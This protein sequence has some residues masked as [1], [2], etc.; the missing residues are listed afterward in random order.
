M[1][2]LMALRVVSLPAT[3][4]SRTKKPNSSEERL[5][6]PSAAT[7]WLTMSAAGHSL[8]AAAMFIE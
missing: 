4:S 6:W 2:W 8:R 1:P 3:A 7:S 5:P